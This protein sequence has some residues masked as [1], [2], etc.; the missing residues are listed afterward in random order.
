MKL[1]I[2]IPVYNSEPYITDLIECLAPQITDEVEVI[3]VDDGSDR[4][5]KTDYSWIKVFRQKNKGA[6]AARNTGLNK[7]QGE[8][9]SFIDSDDM[10]SERYISLILDKI[11]SEHFDYC[12]LSWKTLPGGWRYDVKL[13]S[14]DDKFPPFNLCVWNRVYRRSM[15]GKVRFNTKKAIAEDAQFIR[16]VKEQGK[17]KAFISEYMYFYRDNPNS[18]TK[19]VAE[20]KI[21]F[22]RICYYYDHIT[23][24]MTWLIDEVAE[25]DKT[26]EVIIMTKKNDLPKLEDHAMVIRPMA[27]KCT[28]LRGEYTSMAE[29][30]KKPIK[31]QVVLYTYWTDIIGGIE[32][33]IYS[34]CM[35]M[36]KYYDITVVYDVAAPEQISRL[37]SIVQVVKNDKKQIIECDTLIMNRILDKIPENIKY[38]KSVQIVNGAKVKG[39]PLPKD[40]DE[41]VCVSEFVKKDWGE[42]TK[43]ATA[44]LNMTSIDVPK[45]DTLLLVSATRIDTE[46]KGS[47]RMLKLAQIMKQKGVSFI[48]MVFTNRP[49]PAEAPQEMVRMEPTLDILKYIKKADYLVQLSDKE[50]FCY[51]LVESL[52]VGTPVI[53]TDLAVLPEIGVRNGENGYVLPLDFDDLDVEKFLDIP[54]FK[55]TFNNSP[56]VTRWKNLLGNTKPTHSYKPSEILKVR[57]IQE[58]KDLEL[59]KLL[60]PGDVVPMR[61]ERALLVSEKG[62][63]EIME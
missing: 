20:G 59:D 58:Y 30:I 11:D 62:M 19:R 49:L 12:Y 40:R 2:I 44:I 48:W 24:D 29:I 10:V 42:D 57:V 31:T 6:A 35:R 18:L 46:D 34:F 53:V 52:T 28:E 33:F 39:Y 7:A 45:T 63:G 43:D 60:K 50:G 13:R 47:N 14:I 17:K 21:D 26:S 38:K 1:S 36:K 32:T 5:F 55:Y 16:D 9:I 4:A 51:S 61:R 25:L 8:Y 15:I 41:I 27:V 23:S 3:V 56:S 37:Y 22:D 54:K